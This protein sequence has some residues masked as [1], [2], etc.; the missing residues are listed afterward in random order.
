MTYWTIMTVTILSGGLDGQ[1][2]VIPYPS[3]AECEA[4]T[5]VISATLSYDHN[6]VCTETVKPSSPVISPEEMRP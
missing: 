3:M 5:V 1:K 2:F 4:A 6:M